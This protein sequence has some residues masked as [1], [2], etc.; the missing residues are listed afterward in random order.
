MSLTSTGLNSGVS[1]DGRALARNAAVTLNQDSITTSAC[2]ATTPGG[3][4]GTNLTASGS[5]LASASGASGT[6]I[7]KFPNTGS[8]PDR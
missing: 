4:T 7:P 2:A 3:G 6:V 8:G 5:G 1:L